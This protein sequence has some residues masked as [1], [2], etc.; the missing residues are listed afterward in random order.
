M[1]NKQT[2]RELERFHQHTRMFQAIELFYA[3]EQIKELTSH[4]TQEIFEPLKQQMLEKIESYTEKELKTL[5]T[6][7][8]LE[9]ELEFFKIL[10]GSR[11]NK[12]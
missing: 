11:E 1:S 7:F 3:I 8:M 4:N 2:R 9:D 12:C 6:N 5:F 10:E